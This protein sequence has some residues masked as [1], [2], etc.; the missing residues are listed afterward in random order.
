MKKA[1][2]LWLCLFFF[3]SL[4]VFEATQFRRLT[5]RLRKRAISGWK[6]VNGVV[7]LV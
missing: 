6:L 5:P 7:S 4:Q 2:P 3:V 1:E